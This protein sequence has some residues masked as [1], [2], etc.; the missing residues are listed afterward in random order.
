MKVLILVTSAA[1]LAPGHPTGVWLEEYAI[2][3]TALCITGVDITVASPAGGPGPIDPKTAPDSAASAKWRTALEALSSTA[4]LADMKA[5]DYDAVFVPGGHGPMVDLASSD[6]AARLI[7]DFAAQGRIVAAVCHGPAALLNVAGPDGR[8]FVAGR[9]LTAF[10]NG[11]EIAA[12]LKAM[13][14]FLLE[15]RLKAAGAAFEHALLPGACHVVV[16]GR[17]ITGQNPASSEA[18]AKALSEALSARQAAA[19]AAGA[20]V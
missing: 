17:L 2:P 13:V 8:P 10:T 12:G 9:R 20:A 7:G 1:E 5:E 4:R 14:P 18:L 16:D 15:D 6:A 11:E 19:L 3:Y